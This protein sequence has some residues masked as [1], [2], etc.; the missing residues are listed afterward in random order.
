MCVYCMFADLAEQYRKGRVFFMY[1]YV[2]V[3]AYPLEDMLSKGH[4]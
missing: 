2:H 1:L 3:N 4:D